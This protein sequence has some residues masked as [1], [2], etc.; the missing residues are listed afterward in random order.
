MAAIEAQIQR[1]KRL[2]P[3]K[4][5]SNSVDEGEPSISGAF[6]VVESVKENIKLDEDDKRDEEVSGYGEMG[7]EQGMDKPVG[8]VEHAVNGGGKEVEINGL[9]ESIQE[10]KGKVNVA[11]DE[12]L[13]LI[14]KGY[15]ESTEIVV[16]GNLKA[17]PNEVQSEEEG[18]EADVAK[19]DDDDS[20]KGKQKFEDV[21]GRNEK[22]ISQPLFLLEASNVTYIDSNPDWA[23][24]VAINDCS[25]PDIVEYCIS[26][27]MEGD[28]LKQAGKKVETTGHACH[29]FNDMPK[30][31]SKEQANV[32]TVKP[33]AAA[34]VVG[35]QNSSASLLGNRCQSSINLEYVVSKLSDCS[36]IIEIEDDLVDGESWT[37]CIVGYFMGEDMAFG[38]VRATAKTLWGRLGLEDVYGN[39]NGFYFFFF[40]FG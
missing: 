28:R 1:I 27:S 40:F 10:V 5:V 38:L 15:D 9:E 25:H 17:G 26:K 16:A 21:S 31:S 24:T 29:M 7:P 4:L 11:P 8:K 13:K 12:S 34:Q 3:V 2:S 39:N 23:H 22:G 19:S 18:T 20:N 30:S 37:N 33:S 32:P 6:K 14:K 36:E 35:K